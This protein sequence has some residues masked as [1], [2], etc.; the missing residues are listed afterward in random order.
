MKTLSGYSIDLSANQQR[1]TQACGHIYHNKW[2]KIWKLAF[3][4]KSK[5]SKARRRSKPKT[6]S[7]DI[8]QRK[9]LAILFWITKI[10]RRKWHTI[11]SIHCLTHILQRKGSTSREET[12]AKW[13]FYHQSPK[14]AHYCKVS[15]LQDQRENPQRRKM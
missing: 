9:K 5:A 6:K 3:K 7:C 10:N 14:Q 8:K 12:H 1:W 4:M 2:S 13:S 11:V 15:R